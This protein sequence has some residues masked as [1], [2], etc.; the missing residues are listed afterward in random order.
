MS[1]ELS[2]DRRGVLANITGFANH[3]LDPYGRPARN[4]RE[5]TIYR[6]AAACA[7]LA[8]QS[9]RPI[10]RYDVQADPSPNS[11]E[12]FVEACRAIIEDLELDVGLV[13]MAPPDNNPYKH[14]N[15]CVP[16]LRTY[17]ELAIQIGACSADGPLF[18][19]WQDD[20]NQPAISGDEK[21][22]A[23]DRIATALALS[24]AGLT[25]H[26]D[27]W[28]IGAEYLSGWHDEA[29]PDKGDTAREFRTYSSISAAR[30][31]TR[32]A[33]EKAKA[34][35]VELDNYRKLFTLLVDTA[36]TAYPKRGLAEVEALVEEELLPAIK[37][38]D[39]NLIHLSRRNDRGRFESGSEEEQQI[40]RRIVEEA[41]E[42]GYEG[43]YAAEVFDP[44]DTA[45][46]ALGLPEDS[47]ISQ[48]NKVDP[49][50]GYFAGIE[51]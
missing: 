14:G 47:D 39:V 43:P 37:D 41:E 8:R 1:V 22:K 9:G 3:L 17:W 6:H 50:L 12:L 25:F 30:P 40:V 16:L 51:E 23:D 48:G 35:G 42:A 44:K 49:L 4:P 45:V 38:D 29:H 13:V 33:S 32:L 21:T 26:D 28:G 27:F 36:H 2:D 18:E 46:A 5:T 10:S 20:I 31:V 24:V 19:G 34:A 11:R 15:D 7:W